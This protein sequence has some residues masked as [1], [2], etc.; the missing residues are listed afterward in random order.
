MLF[1]QRY[2]K[3]PALRRPPGFRHPT[4][5]AR[6][7]RRSSL[8]RSATRGLDIRIARRTP[9]SHTRGTIMKL[10]ARTPG[11][12]FR[13]PAPGN[14]RGCGRTP[15]DH[16]TSPAFCVTKD[17]KRLVREIQNMGMDTNP[18]DESVPEEIAWAREALA[19][20]DA[21]RL[22]EPDGTPNE[23]ARAELEWIRNYISAARADSS[24]D[25]R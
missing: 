7:I 10:R 20:F 4:R 8:R 17:P 2:R 12:G 13:R 11:C 15:W 14:P 18:L 5:N 23:Q 9:L 6:T 22:F 24:T 21:A 19:T 3:R 25:R 16:G 1:E